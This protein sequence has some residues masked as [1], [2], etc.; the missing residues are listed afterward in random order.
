MS[1][2][3]KTT[4]VDDLLAIPRPS[5]SEQTPRPILGIDGNLIELGSKETHSGTSAFILG[6]ND[7]TLPEICKHLDVEH[8]GFYEMRVTDLSPLTKLKR[9]KTLSINWNSKLIDI[10]PLTELNELQAL[11]FEDTPKIN[12][13]SPLSVLSQLKALE[14]SG[15]FASPPNKAATLSPIAELANL[16]DLRL[17]NIRVA[18]DGL[19]PLA[20]CKSLETLKL[21]NT[22]PTE[23][24]AYLAAQLLTTACDSFSGAI[25]L[26]SPIGGNDTMIVGSRKP[27]LNSRKDTD[28][29]QKYVS[30]F[31]RMKAKSS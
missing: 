25:K 17:T 7:K 28:R 9:L 4:L 11:G 27:F 22:F 8:L 12:D 16:R 23:E 10:S 5:W 14:F 15:G 31:E 26:D 30:A 2:D 18:Q 19:K 13:L 20:S 29:I 1:R 6:A 21:A 24:Y 3:E